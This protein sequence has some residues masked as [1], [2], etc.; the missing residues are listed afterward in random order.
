MIIDPALGRFMMMDPHAENYYS[1]SPYAYVGNNPIK[2][3]DPTGMVIDDYYNEYGEYLYTDTQETDNIRII[4]Q[5]DWET[6]QNTYGNEITLIRDLNASSKAINNADLSPEAL[7]NIFTDITSKMPDLNLNQLH[8][9]K[10]S[11]ST[12]RRTSD[13]K[14]TGYNDPYTGWEVVFAM[15]VRFAEGKSRVTIPVGN[16]VNSLYLLGTVSNVQSTMVHELEGHEMRG[17]SG[18]AGEA[19]AYMLQRNHASWSKTTT[20]YQKMIRANYYDYTGKTMP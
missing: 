12:G 16:T 2:Y 17:Y 6:I 10:V 14:E 9:G 4:K 15:H 8:N 11:I 18:A 13:G 20:E 3:I 5:S 7:S 1:I 19:E